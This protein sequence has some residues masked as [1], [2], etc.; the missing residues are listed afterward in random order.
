MSVEKWRRKFN[1]AYSEVWTCVV[2]GYRT[3]DRLRK[4]PICNGAMEYR[5]EKK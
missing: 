3:K 4:C 5:A 1:K 2:C